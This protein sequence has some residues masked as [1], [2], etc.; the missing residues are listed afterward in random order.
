MSGSSASDSA[1]L[2]PMLARLWVSEAETTTST[3]VNPAP[4]ARCDAAAV[5]GEG[6]VADP[7]VLLH[8]RPHLGG[9]GHLRDGLGADEAHGLD[10]GQAGARERIDEPDL[11]G[12]GHGRL[13]LEPVARSDLPQRDPIR[14]VH[15]RLPGPR[16]V[17]AHPPMLTPD[18]G[19]RDGRRQERRRHHDQRTTAKA[20]GQR[21][22][23]GEGRD[24][25]R[26]G[27]AAVKACSQGW[28]CGGWVGWGRG[29]GPQSGSISPT[30][31]AADCRRHRSAAA[32]QAADSARDHVRQ[33]AGSSS[34]ERTPE[35]GGVG[36]SRSGRPA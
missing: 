10:A 32:R 36:D 5:G 6:A 25:R 2:R 18:P 11:V 9:V 20:N 3:A 31:E 17:A 14:L 28:W 22:P 23:S 30:G 8:G 7:G 35:P 4:R 12:G 1:T 34:G 21:K 15:V 33:T 27:N 29:E 19:M 26:H 24:A 16:P 13:V